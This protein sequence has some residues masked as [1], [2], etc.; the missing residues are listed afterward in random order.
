MHVLRK[1]YLLL[2]IMCMV[3]CD[4]R[5]TDLEAEPEPCEALLARIE[6]CIGGR[7]A[8]SGLCV[9]EQAERLLTMSCAEI[10]IYLRGE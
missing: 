4:H 10:V 8:L 3:T 6:D 1:C 5:D 7:P 9:D 2:L